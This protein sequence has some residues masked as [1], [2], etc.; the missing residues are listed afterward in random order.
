MTVRHIKQALLRPQFN[1]APNASRPGLV[2]VAIGSGTDP[3]NITPDRAEHLADD[4]LA[5]AAAAR[6][7]GGTA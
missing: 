1:V 4:L 2:V 3:Y 6:R 5:A 7:A